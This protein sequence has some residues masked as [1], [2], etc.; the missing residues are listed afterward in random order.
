ML[1]QSF[2]NLHQINARDIVDA[3]R[4]APD[5]AVAVD[6]SNTVASHLMLTDLDIRATEAQNLHCVDRQ[7]G[8]AAVAAAVAVEYFPRI[9]DVAKC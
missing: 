3:E 2:T 4:D 9:H 8:V 1:L 7:I 5:F 6:A